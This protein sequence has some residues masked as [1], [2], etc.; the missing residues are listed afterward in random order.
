MK[1]LSYAQKYALY[2]EF[3]QEPSRDIQFLN[4]IF[5]KIRK[6]KIPHKVKEDFCGSFYF[7]SEWVKSH[8]KRKAVAVDIDWEPLRQGYHSYYNEMSSDQKN[9]LTIIQG[10]V[11]HKFGDSVDIN[12]ASNFSYN[13][14]KE[15]TQLKKYFKSVFENLNSRGIFVMDHFGGADTLM[16]Y[17][18]RIPSKLLGEKWYYEWEL[19]KYNPNT[20]EALYYI[21][22]SRSKSKREF[23]RVFTYDWRMW[24]LQELK[25]ILLEVGFKDVAFYWED[26]RDHFSLKPQGDTSLST[27]VVHV[28]GIK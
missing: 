12:F 14:I 1:R 9:R 19:K 28:V 13:C 4:R 24:S 18:D 23:P 11:C 3:V 17:L 7:S 6:G 15:R 27:W 20:A 2:C 25:D 8:K 10:D 21:H 26:D 5:K 22:F 16:P